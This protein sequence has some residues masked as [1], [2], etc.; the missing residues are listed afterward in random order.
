[1]IEAELAFIDTTR[2]LLDVMESMIKE[3]LGQVIRTNL[4]DIE[5]YKKFSGEAPNMAKVDILLN[6]DFEVM[7]YN[8]ALDI[9]SAA[10]PKT[11]KVRGPM[12]GQNF[13][14]EH[15]K[16]L[17]EKH[18]KGVP[19]FITDWH[20]DTKPFYARVDQ[21]NNGTLQARVLGH[22]GLNNAAEEIFIMILIASLLATVALFSILFILLQIFSAMA[23]SAFPPSCKHCLTFF[24]IRRVT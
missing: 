19:V 13:G 11:F 1:M 4:E 12:A 16:Y 14:K 2:E 21:D 15:E 5:L 8:E 22:R 7:T 20:P 18:C 3:S 17:V 10:K 6:N 23:L 24:H 9:L